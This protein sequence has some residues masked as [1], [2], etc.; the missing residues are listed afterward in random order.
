[1]DLPLTGERTV[2]GIWHETYWFRRHEVVY[3]WVSRRIDAR[4]PAAAERVLD[5]GCGE[6][7]GADRLTRELG[8]TVIGLDYDAATTAHARGRYGLPVAR[9]NL[10]QLPFARRVF[11]AVVSLQTV[12]HLWDQPAF[13][14]ECLRVLAPGGTL[15]LSTPNRLTFPPGNICHAREL[16]AAELADLLAPADTGVVRMYG[17]WHGPRLRAWESAHGPLPRAQLET[18]PDAWPSG[19]ADLVR[20]VTTADFTLAAAD[21]PADLESCLD[22]VLAVG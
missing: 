10:V 21:A 9:G 13:V 16:T 8:R 15:V 5:A 2:P 18:S 17:L 11:D 1:M 4:T 22:L 19:L 14:R 7:Y 6:G 20:S 3:E 12:E